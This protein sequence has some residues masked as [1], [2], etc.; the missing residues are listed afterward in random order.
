MT[1]PR[2]REEAAGGL[3]ARTAEHSSA[4]VAQD[5]PDHAPDGP[6]AASASG[7]EPSLADL[8]H[9]EHDQGPRAGRA[10][11]FAALLVPLVFGL[12]ALLQSVRLGVGDPQDPGPGLWPVLTS[13]AVIAC[14]IVL[15]LTERTEADYEKYTR[16]A[17]TNML[18]IASLVV[19]VV[20]FQL[21]GFEVAT[22]LV[23]AFWLKVLGGESWRTTIVM[24]VALTVSLYVLF[25]AVL[26]APLPRLLVL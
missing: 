24:S 8:L 26:G 22:L 15:L 5:G 20:L 6:A 25:V 21:A 3:A 2:E 13:G 9:G 19:Y 17:L 16:G 14:A 18:G 4:A 10:V 12:A 11:R 23:S 7:A 1:T